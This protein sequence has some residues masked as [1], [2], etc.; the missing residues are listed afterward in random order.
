VDVTQLGLNGE[1]RPG[2]HDVAFTAL[3]D[4]VRKV[5]IRARFTVQ[6][7]DAGTVTAPSLC[8]VRVGEHEHDSPRLGREHGRSR[9][10]G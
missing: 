1:L 5:V 6:K 2:L 3:R 4:D 10:P 8:V 7:H 9:A